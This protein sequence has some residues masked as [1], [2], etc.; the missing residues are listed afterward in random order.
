MNIDRLNR[1]SLIGIE[2]AFPLA[3]NFIAL[4]LIPSLGRIR[5]GKAGQ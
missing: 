5:V 1:A 3:D 4:T 2:N